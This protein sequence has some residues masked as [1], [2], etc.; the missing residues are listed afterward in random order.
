MI[1]EF[2]D[3][4]LRAKEYPHE[5]RIIRLLLLTV[6]IVSSVSAGRP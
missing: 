2:K 6:E 5:K 1:N 3:V 4:S